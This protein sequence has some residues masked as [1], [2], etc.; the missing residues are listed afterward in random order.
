MKLAIF[1]SSGRTGVELVKQALE[2]DHKVTAFLRD[3]AR[4]PVQHD[5]LETITGDVLTGENIADAVQGQDA[6]VCVLGSN[7][8]KKTDI[9]ST[10]TANI[11]QAMK[12]QNVQRYIV[13]SAMG[14]GD[15]WDTLSSTGKFLY[16]T[17]LKNS[18]SDHEAQEIAVKAS[19]L[20]WTIIRPSGLTDEPKTG[21][22]EVGENIPA[23]TSRI[24][25][26]DVADLVL[27]EL[28]QNAFIGKA[29]TITN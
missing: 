3:P 14:T 18:R 16:A 28:E 10:G 27:K 1:G 29:V 20:A 12:Q 11:I 15:S 24:A 26:A 8:L 9:R 6:V 23:K 19:D 5:Q 21:E 2:K 25:R 17:V 13:V 22:Y 4:L 7:D